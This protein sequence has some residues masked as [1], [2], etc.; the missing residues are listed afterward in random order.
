MSSVEPCRS[1]V[2]YR[3]LTGLAA[4]RT[5]TRFCEAAKAG[6][7]AQRACGALVAAG[8]VEAEGW[9]GGAWVPEF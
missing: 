4:K 9:F 1:C 5:K 6:A 7:A 8:S 3:F 2:G